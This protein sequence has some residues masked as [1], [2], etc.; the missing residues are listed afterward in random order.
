MKSQLGYPSF[1]ERM[2]ELNRFIVNLTKEYNAGNITSWDN[3]DERVKKFFTPEQMSE[4]ETIVP[5]WKKM[6][7]YSDGIT[8]THV[9]CVFLGLFMLPEFQKLSE[10]QQQLAKW[11]VLFHDIDKLHVRGKK[12]T[13]HA[14]R[15]GAVA[16]NILPNIGFPIS[17]QYHVFIAPWTTLTVNAFVEDHNKP[18]QK[19]DN[20]KLPEILAGID[21]LFGEDTAATIIVKTCLLHI[22]LSVDPHYNT[23]APL[24]DEE[25]KQFISPALFPLLRVMMLVDNEGW[26]MFDPET[27][28]RQRRD[29]LEAFAKIELMV[30]EEA[31]L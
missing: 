30:N 29:T 20:T 27:R 14:F 6:A 4:F 7:S 25:V 22:S 18:W 24:T 23:P 2:P 11:I 16:A 13:L 28:A 12:D 21:Q 8:L 1:D 31:K 15:S 9:T 26:S 5:G 10:N 3:L 17:V 19:P